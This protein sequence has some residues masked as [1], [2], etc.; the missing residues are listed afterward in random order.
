[1]NWLI[2]YANRFNRFINTLKK[3][4]MKEMQEKYPWS[5]PS[6]ERKYMSEGKY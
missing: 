3:E 5:D 6:G 1:M 4:R 2:L